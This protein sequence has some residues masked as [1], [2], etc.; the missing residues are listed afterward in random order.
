M[1]LYYKAQQVALADQQRYHVAA[2]LLR[3]KSIL[4]VSTNSQKTHPRNERRYLDGGR[5]YCHHA[6]TSALLN[7]K[8]GDRLV[9]LRFLKSGK[10]TCARPCKYCQSQLKDAQVDVY[11]S[12]WNGMV[13]RFR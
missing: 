4:R 5:S 8:P 2:L 6:E 10:L 13:Q 12:D 7:A 9:V 3:G 11:Y 1:T